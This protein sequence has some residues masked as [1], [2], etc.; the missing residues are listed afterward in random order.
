MNAVKPGNNHEKGIQQ[1]EEISQLPTAELLK[2]D[3]TKLFP[4]AL[5]VFKDIRTT[6][7]SN[8]VIAN[9]EGQ[10]LGYIGRP[11]DQRT[12]KQDPS[13]MGIY[14][15]LTN[16]DDLETTPLK[17]NNDELRVDDMNEYKELIMSPTLKKLFPNLKYNL[18][19]S[20][21]GKEIDQADTST[22]DINEISI[23]SNTFPL[24]LLFF[25]NLIKQA[26]ESNITLEQMMQSKNVN[27][28][29]ELVLN[30]IQENFT[31]GQLNLAL[32]EQLYLALQGTVLNKELPPYGWTTQ[33]SAITAGSLFDLKDNGFYKKEASF[34]RD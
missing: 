34:Y 8:F 1:R 13:G 22:P 3:P 20:R 30:E 23:N 12:R 4:E 24:R 5:E 26:K 28:I 29:G 6:E 18:V 32:Y 25:A 14:D 27:D 9:M 2:L 11:G 31:T 16:N 33:K 21:T 7:L 19:A 15:L 17:I 10:Q